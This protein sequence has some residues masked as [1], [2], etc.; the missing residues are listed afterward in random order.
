MIAVTGDQHQLSIQE[1]TL[2]HAARRLTAQLDIRGPISGPQD[3]ARLLGLKP[4]ALHAGIKRL[5]IRRPTMGRPAAEL[6]ETG[7]GAAALS[8]DG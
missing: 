3:A 8:R 1:E 4:R 5:G 2:T 7:A 6:S